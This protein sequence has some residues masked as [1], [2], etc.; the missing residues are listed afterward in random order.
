M[1]TN[2]VTPLPPSLSLLPKMMFCEEEEWLSVLAFSFFTYA[3]LKRIGSFYSVTLWLASL[4]LIE[5]DVTD[6]SLEV[7]SLLCC[8]EG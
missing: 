3:L 6:I 1:A 2:Y 4:I 5:W 8:F 7:E